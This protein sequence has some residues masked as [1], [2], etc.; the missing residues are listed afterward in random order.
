MI[1]EEMLLFAAIMTFGTG[2]LCAA[3]MAVERMTEKINTARTGIKGE[4]SSN[5]MFILSL[6]F[7]FIS[8]LF[9]NGAM[10]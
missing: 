7:F 2:I 1:I 6:G 10:F 5:N 8:A 9:A 4:K 3:L